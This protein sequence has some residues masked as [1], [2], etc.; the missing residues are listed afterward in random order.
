MSS[1]DDW[2]GLDLNSWL[3]DLNR[4]LLDRV[5]LATPDA[6]RDSRVTA[7][8]VAA[9]WLGSPGA[10]D[11]EIRDVEAG[12]G[13]ALPPGYRS[14]LQASDGFLLPGLIVPRFR[15]A[16]ELRWLRDE[17]PKTVAT[18]AEYA[19]PGSVESELDGCLQ[20]SDRELVGT[21]VHLLNPARRHGEE[22][23]AVHL[24]HWSPG[25]ESFPSFRHLLVEERR[26]FADWAASEDANRARKPP[27]QAVLRR[28][29]GRG[30]DT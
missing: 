14:F 3:E 27:W 8:V 18:W 25:A 7:E 19:E 22:W 30:R 2:E 16:G 15:S 5:D 21:A 13:T 6:F 17:D 24:A 9:G 29:S 20:I 1:A 11:D 23:E 4:E 12:L 28:F 10:S 26:R